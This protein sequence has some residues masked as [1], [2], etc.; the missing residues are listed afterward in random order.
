VSQPDGDTLTPE[1]KAALQAFLAH[2]MAQ[3]PEG[4]SMDDRDLA[5]IEREVTQAIAADPRSAYLLLISVAQAW[6]QCL[7]DLGFSLDTLDENNA[8]MDETFGF[9]S[10]AL[11]TAVKTYAFIG[12]QIG[13]GAIPSPDE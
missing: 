10:E 3:P 13:S 8:A 12:H 9:V 7:Y 4:T 5:D 2:R 6:G 1:Q 11:H